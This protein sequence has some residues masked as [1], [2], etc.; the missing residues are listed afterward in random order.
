MQTVAPS[1]SD[2][3]P[4]SYTES[5]NSTAVITAGGQQWTLLASTFYADT[6]N[7][8]TGDTLTMLGNKVAV[9]KTA[10]ALESHFINSPAV[11]FNGVQY[12]NTA[13]TITFPAPQPPCQPLA[14][15]APLGTGGR[16]VQLVESS[17]ASM[18]LKEDG[19]VWTTGSGY[20][21]MLGN[22]EF[23][24]RHTW[25][26]VATGA[27]KIMATPDAFFFIKTDG[28]V[29]GTGGLSE[30]LG[31]DYFEVPKFTQLPV[32]DVA[33][34]TQGI[35]AVFVQR[36]D[37][38]L[39]QLSGEIF[40]TSGRDFSSPLL[41]ESNVRKAYPGS[42]GFYV[43]KTDNSVWQHPYSG[44]SSKLADNV[45]HFSMG[46]DT[47]LWVGTDG[48]AYARGN[49]ATR[50]NVFGQNSATWS[51]PTATRIAAAA[52]PVKWASIGT[53]RTYVLGTDG[54]LWAA[55]CGDRWG[56]VS[57]FADGTFSNRPTFS[58]MASGVKMFTGTFVVNTAD[59]LFANGFNYSGQFGN[60]TDEDS[61]TFV[62]VQY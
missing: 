54:Q 60:G 39:W 10:S 18:M 8:T 58:P 25:T 43:L 47:V 15:N 33:D 48:F 13:G 52:G 26:R 49:D 37:G 23:D 2:T 29:W 16:L 5:T 27:T 59:A 55:G 17:D 21:G 53:N 45:A 28:T 32:S 19:S 44:T 42:H 56:E 1:S 62:P 30:F 9:G 31:S 3:N 14:K 6:D 24:D 4:M 40:D 41:V 61:M 57:Y 51:Y 35:G 12:Q 11:T 34:I 50:C 7:R 20:E 22:C 38:T 46:N 36:T